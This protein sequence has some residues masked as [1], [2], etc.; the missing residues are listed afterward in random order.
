M[1]LSMR[2]IHAMI[3]SATKHPSTAGE[4][5]VS[6]RRDRMELTCL[7]S[8]SENAVNTAMVVE[9]GSRVNSPEEDDWWWRV[10][11]MIWWQMRAMRTP[12]GF[13][14]FA[15]F[16]TDRTNVRVRDCALH[17]DNNWMLPG[18]VLDVYTALYWYWYWFVRREGKGRLDTVL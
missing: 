9:S 6:L 11:V 12:I 13:I 3:M 4:K 5:S 17:L 18:L 8:R 16:H 15:T 14:R 10:S 7:W 1:G 2:M